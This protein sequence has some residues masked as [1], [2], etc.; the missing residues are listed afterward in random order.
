MRLRSIALA[1]M[2]E[3][4]I[5]AQD[6]LDRTLQAATDALRAFQELKDAK[7]CSIGDIFY[8]FLFIFGFIL[9]RRSLVIVSKRCRRFAPWHGCAWTVGKSIRPGAHHI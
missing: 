5:A 9:A 3:C 4:S 6:G 2:V 8:H 7:K 1:A